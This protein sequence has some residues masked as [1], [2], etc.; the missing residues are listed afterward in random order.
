MHLCVEI[1]L[2]IKTKTKHFFIKKETKSCL[3]SKI[4]V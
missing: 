1:M 4:D 2:A 3:D